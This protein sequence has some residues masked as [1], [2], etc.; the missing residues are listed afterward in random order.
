MRVAIRREFPAGAVP[1]GIAAICRR[2]PVRRPARDAERLRTEL[3]RF[4][5][6]IFERTPR[7]R[8]SVKRAAPHLLDEPAASRRPHREGLNCD[9]RGVVRGDPN[10]TDTVARLWREQE[11]RPDA[12]APK[13]FGAVSE[14]ALPS[15][16]EASSDGF[17][18]D[19][20]SWPV[21]PTTWRYP[22][23]LMAAGI[24]F[25]KIKILNN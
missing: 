9:H 17:G 23:P 7:A 5:R 20:W 24:F 16:H 13:P 14:I 2:A 19:R 22:G 18:P 21:W 4:L 12:N 25:S 3:R 8:A 1:S 10:Q 6:D 15:L 11:K